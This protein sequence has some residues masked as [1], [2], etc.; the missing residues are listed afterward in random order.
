M[1][2]DDMSIPEY[3]NYLMSKWHKFDWYEDVN[4]FVKICRKIKHLIQK[5]RCGFVGENC[6]YCG[7][8]LP[9]EALRG[10]G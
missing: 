1:K 7:R 10:T 3:R 6:I 5:R 4:I 8:K 9:P 2:I